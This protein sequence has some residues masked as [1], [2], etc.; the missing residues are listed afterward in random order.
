MKDGLVDEGGL[1]HEECL[2]EDSVLCGVLSAQRGMRPGTPAR[3]VEQDALY[4]V[5]A[6]DIQVGG[7]ASSGCGWSTFLPVPRQSGVKP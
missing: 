1:W 7:R 2:P 3:A 6:C 4:T 5:Q